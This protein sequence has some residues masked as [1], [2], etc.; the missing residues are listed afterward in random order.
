MKPSKLVDLTKAVNGVSDD[1]VIMYSIHAFSAPKIVIDF[2]KNLKQTNGTAS[3]IAVG[4]NEAWLN[5]G[6]SS[7][8][9]KILT[10]KGYQIK[11]N[12][13]IA[14]PLSFVKRFPAEL[15]IKLVRDGT[16]KIEEI[17]KDLE[18][19]EQK[20]IAFKSKAITVVGALEKQAAKV[21]GLELH[22]NKSCTSCSVCWTSCPAGNIKEKNGKPKFGFKCTMCMKCIY[23]CPENSIS[24]YISKFLPLKNGYNVEDYE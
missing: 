15:S 11:H 8:I 6:S 5:D 2:V 9:V 17:A 19:V 1:L 10:E 21:F 20:E 24:P 16:R 4:C 7:K 14:M 22:A 12:A 13:V 18:Y 23:D 3:I